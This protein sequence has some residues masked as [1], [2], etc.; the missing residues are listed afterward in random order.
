MQLR[1]QVILAL[2]EVYDPEISINV[3]DLGLIYGIEVNGD[4]CE[5]THTL[6]SMMCPFADQICEDIYNACMSVEGVN[7]CHRELVFFPP[8]GPHMIPE[9]TRMVM[10]IDI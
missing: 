5:V 3:Y 6:T 4:H 10:G 8:F 1:N 7:S 9:E 2:K